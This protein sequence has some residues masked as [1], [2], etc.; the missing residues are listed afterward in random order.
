MSLRSPKRTWR[1]QKSH[2][3]WKFAGKMPDPK[4]TRDILCGILQENRR[5]W[6]PGIAFCARLCSRNAHGAILCENLQE[7]CRTPRE[8]LDSTPGLL[9]LP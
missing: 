8:H 1:G 6:S 2:F 4:P 5:T 7:K 3:V 9:L